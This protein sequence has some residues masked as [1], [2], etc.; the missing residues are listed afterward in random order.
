MNEDA[1]GKKIPKENGTKEPND[2]KTNG[3]KREVVSDSDSDTN[4]KLGKAEVASIP[5]ST[6]DAMADL[7]KVAVADA[8]DMDTGDDSDAAA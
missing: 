6:K 5:I 4:S 3:D 1:D 8:M 2:D 7:E